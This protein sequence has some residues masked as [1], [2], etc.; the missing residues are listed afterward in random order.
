M[1][2]PASDKHVTGTY[3]VLRRSV[4]GGPVMTMAMIDDHH[5]G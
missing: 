4:A 3:Q 2:F 5:A 1:G